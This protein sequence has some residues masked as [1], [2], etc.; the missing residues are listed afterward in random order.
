[1]P[2]LAGRA[3]D[4]KLGELAHLD[5]EPAVS[6]SVAVLGDEGGA[7]SSADSVSGA[8]NKK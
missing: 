4:P 7:R 3:S 1:M 6:R 2:E 8:A 5:I